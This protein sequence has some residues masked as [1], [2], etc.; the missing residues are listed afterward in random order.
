MHEHW[1]QIVRQIFPDSHILDSALEYPITSTGW[2][3]AVPQRTIECEF[4]N[5]DY[6]LFINL[7][8][9]LNGVEL[10]NLHN[11]F[12]DNHFPMHRITV[13]V[14]PKRIQEILPQES[15]N[16]INFSSHQYETWCQYKTN[17]AVLRDA[18]R[19][20]KK[21]F[22]YNFVC[23]QRIFK[24]HRAALHGVLKKYS[25]ANISLQS[26]GEELRYPSLT[27]K[28][29]D[30]TYDNCANLLAMKKN[31]NTAAFSIVSETQYHEQYGIITEKTFNSIVAGVPFLLVAHQGAI[32]DL[33]TYGFQT[34]GGISDGVDR[35]GS[36]FDE[37]YDD[38]DNQIRIK[39]MINSNDSYIKE[40]LTRTEMK[41]L[42]EDCRG[43]TEYNRDY[44]FEQ[45]GDQ[46][47]SEL[48][49]DLLNI[50]GH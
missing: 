16:V 14:W 49:I 34:F 22:K 21:D 11:H 30:S 19:T 20:D 50:W 29:Y 31:Y 24:P 12:A 26:K 1:T 2:D 33:Q 28:E 43:I 3:I 23:P 4:D 38:L 10:I 6:H 9:M 18:F 45:F 44:F 46:L 42:A 48:R 47:I 40:P 35:W 36:I 41:H 37:T 17:E 8:D 5:P 25:H 15:F 32:K 39:D 27:F 13:L 7:Q